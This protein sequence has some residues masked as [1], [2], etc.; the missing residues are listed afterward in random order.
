MGVLEMNTYADFR[1]YA[2]MLAEEQVENPTAYGTEEIGIE[3]MVRGSEYI[4]YPTKS[5][6]LLACLW[7]DH[8]TS[9]EDELNEMGFSGDFTSWCTEIVVIALVKETMDCYRR[10]SSSLGR[11]KP[12]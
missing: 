4:V 2:K 12:K 9:A 7:P 1:E 6:K 5:R 8:I 11:E 10:M 3:S